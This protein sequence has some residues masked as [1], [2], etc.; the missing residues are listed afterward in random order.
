MKTPLWPSK[1]N[2]GHGGRGWRRRR[3]RR[4]KW[5]RS[6]FGNRTR[7]GFGNRIRGT[8]A[9]CRIHL[10]HCIR[11]SR[12]PVYEGYE[13]DDARNELH[14]FLQAYGSYAG[15]S[16]EHARLSFLGTRPRTGGIPLHIGRTMDV[17]K[18][19]AHIHRHIV[20]RHSRRADTSPQTMTRIGSTIEPSTCT[21]Q[22]SLG[23]TG[24]TV[25]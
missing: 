19:V 3:R 23:T 10:G 22:H 15:L 6:W 2:R 1:I 12:R 17:R 9:G 11:R 21:R 5:I 13:Y 14:G 16:S 7:C 8:R 24:C 18:H 25:P 4:G 20:R